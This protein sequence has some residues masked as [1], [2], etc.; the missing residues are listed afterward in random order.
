MRHRAALL[1]A[2]LALAA[3]TLAL[4]GRAA[5]VE[6][7][8]RVEITELPATF[9]AGAGAR[10]VTVVATSERNRCLKV[11]WSLLLSV[12]G[13]D[14]DDVEVA[15]DE[16]GDFPV[17]VRNAGAG[18]ARIT[19]VQLDPGQLC[20]GRTVTA[21]YRIGFDDDADPGSV[22]FRVQAFNAGR[23]LLQEASSRS[24]VKGEQEDRDETRSPSPEASPSP[25]ESTAE[26]EETA[27]QGATPEPTSTDA[28]IAA[29]PA[30]GRDSGTPSLLGAGLIVGGILVFLGVGLLLR[31]RLRARRTEPGGQLP[32]GFYPTN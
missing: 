12:D 7:G 11:R 2:V 26:P 5:A 1:S 25:T 20:R 31:L 14:L 27:E 17:Q 24:E 30:S 29:V 28:D 18:A 22:T 21:R 19:D 10:T 15:R 16:D 23:T 6:P 32:T 9:T 4:P 8:F 3:A 13:P